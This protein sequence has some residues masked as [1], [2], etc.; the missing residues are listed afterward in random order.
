MHRQDSL[1]GPVW[2]SFHCDP[3]PLPGDELMARDRRRLAAIEANPD[4][5][6]SLYL[7]RWSRP[8]VSLGYAQ[9]AERDLDVAA[10]DRD[11]V[12]VVRRP[13]GGRAIL[14]VDEWTYSVA[15]PLAAD[16]LGGSL[17]DSV[18]RVATVVQRALASLGVESYL[19]AADSPQRPPAA[20]KAGPACFAQAIGFELTVEGRKLMGSAQRR[21]TRGFLQ[22]GTILV[23]E[24][25]ERLAD[26][27]AGSAEARNRWRHGLVESTVSVRQLVGAAADFERFAKAMETAWAEMTSGRRRRGVPLDTP[28]GA[29]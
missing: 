5:G 23:G 20:G 28:G 25:H 1:S 7:Y 27:L 13:T 4:L 3:E 18:R 15:A 19:A 10:L 17:E 24:G 21:L 29:A 16:R 26:Y 6:P 14:H 2:P 9:R 12:A 22:Q 11:G 8:T